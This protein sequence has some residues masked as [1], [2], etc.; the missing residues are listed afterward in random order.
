[1]FHVK[2]FASG[3]QGG[4]FRENA[5]RAPLDPPQKLFIKQKFFGGSR[6]AA[7]Q[8]SPPGRRR[9]NML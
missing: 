2:H 8:K 5:R 3:G 1:M 9:Q 7:F 6:G 4:S